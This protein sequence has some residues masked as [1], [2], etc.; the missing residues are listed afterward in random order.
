M[1]N[2][3]EDIAAS[4][5]GAG[6]GAGAGG[7]GGAYGDGGGGY[8]AGDADDGDYDD[9]VYYVPTRPTINRPAGAHRGTTMGFPQ[10]VSTKSLRD[11]LTQAVSRSDPWCPGESRYVGVT[12]V[13]RTGA[14][15]WLLKSQALRLR[16]SYASREEAEGALLAALATHG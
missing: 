2:T 1:S 13:M 4:C 3:G 15:P 10:R 6:G 8:G 5:G 9:G 14:R 12:H 16:C 7:D 11:R